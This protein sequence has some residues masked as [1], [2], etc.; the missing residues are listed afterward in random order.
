FSGIERIKIWRYYDVYLEVA[1]I[2]PFSTLFSPLV[3]IMAPG[4]DLEVHD[5]DDMHG[6][7]AWRGERLV[8]VVLSGNEL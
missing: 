1:F 4:P 7:R 3:R 5:S 8:F 6:V 2:F